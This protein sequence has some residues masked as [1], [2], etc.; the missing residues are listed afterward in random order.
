MSD[1][2]A[3]SIVTVTRRTLGVFGGGGGGSY[4][5]G[6][7]KVG[8]LPGMSRPEERVGIPV[9]IISRVEVVYFPPDKGF[10]QRLQKR[11]EASFCTAPHEKQVRPTRK[12]APQE[13]QNAAPVVFA[14]PHVPQRPGRGGT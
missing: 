11:A 13:E 1:F 12:F 2:D 6:K 8:N 14:L 5:S 3:P 9:S 10:P 4:D 7:W